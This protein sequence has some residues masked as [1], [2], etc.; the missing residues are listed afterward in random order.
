MIKAFTPQEAASQHA[1]NVP[2]F[3]IAAVN[4]LLAAKFTGRGSVTLLQKDIVAEITGSRDIS[5]NALYDNHWLDFEPAFEKSGWK[6]V[7]DK[8]GYNESYEANF[9]FTPL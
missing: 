2:D 5:S 3:V 6:V 1:A 4:K 8:P 7:Y 9:T